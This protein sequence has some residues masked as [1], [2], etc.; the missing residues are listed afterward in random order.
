MKM[1][2]ENSQN[3][4]DS[5]AITEM[6][7]EY[8]TSYTATET[9]EHSQDLYSQAAT[10]EV[11]TNSVQT[12]TSPSMTEKSLK[13]PTIKFDPKFEEK[14]TQYLTRIKRDARFANYLMTN[15]IR[16]KDNYDQIDVRER[17]FLDVLLEQ[18]E[19]INNKRGSLNKD[20]IKNDTEYN[21]TI[22][23]VEE[24]IKMETLKPLAR[25]FVDVECTT[26][27][28]HDIFE[29]IYRRIIHYFSNI[30]LQDLKRI[31]KNNH[32]EAMFKAI[33]ESG[34]ALKQNIEYYYTKRCL[35]NFNA[36]ILELVKPEKK[37]ESVIAAATSQYVEDS[38]RIERKNS[39]QSPYGQ[40]GTF[41]SASDSHGSGVKLPGLSS[42]GE[43][44]ESKKDEYSPI[45]NESN[46]SEEENVDN[47]LCSCFS[48][49]FRK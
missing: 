33:S 38:R 25:E 44:P 49:I 16:D 28:R 41:K 2:R 43:K 11:D 20:L 5:V 21:K 45:V 29:Q 13:A 12:N 26:D 35:R 14:L 46:T 3:A 10:T 47:G 23:Q 24:C 18:L 39:L 19:V 32:N 27:R 15:V 22:A 8:N 42:T 1:E 48:F 9:N 7:S 6:D 40:Y 17:S 4:D 37:L 30:I 36:A 34:E 31:F